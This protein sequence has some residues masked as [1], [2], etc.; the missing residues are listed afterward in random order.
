[1][2]KVNTRLVVFSNTNR[3][4]HWPRI[5]GDGGSLNFVYFQPYQ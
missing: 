2:I 5:L 1:M 3:P 4:K